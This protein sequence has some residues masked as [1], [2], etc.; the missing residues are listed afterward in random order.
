VKADPT[1][2]NHIAA[3]MPGMVVTVNV[4]VGDAV[5]KGQKLLALEAMKMQTILTAERD[6]KIAEVHAAAGTQVETGDLLIV[7]EG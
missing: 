4:Q 5:K 2:P 6:A 1:N 7:L 3:G